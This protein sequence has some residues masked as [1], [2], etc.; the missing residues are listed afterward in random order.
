[1]IRDLGAEGDFSFRPV[2][3]ALSPEVGDSHENI[4]LD[5]KSFEH[6][7]CDQYLREFYGFLGEENKALLRFFAAAYKQ[8]PNGIEI[9]EIGG[10]PTIY[11]LISAARVAKTIEFFD[12]I[13]ENLLSV[14]QWKESS[15]GVIDW[16][17]YFEYALACEMDHSDEYDIS[18]RID[19]LQNCLEIKGHCDVFLENPINIASHTYD[20]VSTNFVA[21]SVTSLL[22]SWNTIVENIVSLV[23]PG[24][25]LIMTAL[26]GATHWQ[27]GQNAF[28][29][30][31]LSGETITKK[32]EQLGF[33]TVLYSAIPAES[34]NTILENRPHGYTGM[35]CVLARRF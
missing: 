11:Q 25:H 3:D 1:M 6:F 15:H 20:L 13:P 32:L 14:Q 8:V 9:A 24:G 34:S 18:R 10:G 22:D 31:C 28:P 16:T 27:D 26:T 23:N 21:D 30:V 12:Y 33:E 5:D 19:T 17:P 4:A 2:R 29:A 7:D 35:Y